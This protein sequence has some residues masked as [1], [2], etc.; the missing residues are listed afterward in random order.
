V[1]RVRFTREEKQQR[2]A[3]TRTLAD[4]NASAS[5]TY[6]ARLLLKQTESDAVE[7]AEKNVQRS[8]APIV[9]HRSEVP[10]DPN[11]RRFMDALEA[12]LERQNETV[13]AE[14]SPETPAASVAPCAPAPQAPTSD[15]ICTLCLIPL[16][17]C[18][19]GNQSQ[20]RGGTQ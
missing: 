15:E 10:V 14:A 8:D 7:R 3:A 2:A 12:M 11:L 5:A 16:G 20:L 9:I 18:G 17:N 6:H 1:T 19:H 13:T 4:Q